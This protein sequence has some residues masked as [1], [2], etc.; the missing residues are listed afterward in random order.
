VWWF[1]QLGILLIERKAGSST[2]HDHS[3]ANNHAPLGMTV[4]CCCGG[5]TLGMAVLLDGLMKSKE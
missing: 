3:Q 1:A 4:T 2:P 5:F